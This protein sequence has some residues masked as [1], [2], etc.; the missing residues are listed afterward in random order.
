MKAQLVFTLPDDD[1]DFRL[2]SNASRLASALYDTVNSLRNRIKYQD[3]L[4][5]GEK[6]F[7][8]ELKAAIY[9]DVSDLLDL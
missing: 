4:E 8:E 9:A 3:N 6:E 5:R 1:A 2:A 7:L